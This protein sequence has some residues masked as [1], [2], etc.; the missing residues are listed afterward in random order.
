MSRSTAGYTKD[1]SLKP[2]GCIKITLFDP[3]IPGPESKQN[4]QL[5]ETCDVK[6]KHRLCFA[7]GKCVSPEPGLPP[8]LCRSHPHTRE[9]HKQAPHICALRFRPLLPLAV[10]HHT[11]N[12]GPQ[13]WLSNNDLNTLAFRPHART[14]CVGNPFAWLL[15]NAAMSWLKK[16]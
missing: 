1:I 13:K 8:M 5:M 3:R 14:C 16:L 12:P 2:R 9:L 11:S 15:S 7:G 4:F 6:I 10:A